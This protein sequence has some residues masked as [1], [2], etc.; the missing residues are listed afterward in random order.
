MF[1]FQAIDSF[2]SEDFT[3]LS[4]FLQ[5]QP[6]PDQFDD[7]YDSNGYTILSNAILENNFRVVNL[8]VEQGE[9]V[10]LANRDGSLPLDLAILKQN[11]QIIDLLI[12]KGARNK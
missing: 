10:N 8:L 9:N 2:G 11:H 1:D 7:I 3:S 4:T 6:Q 12:Q 5:Q